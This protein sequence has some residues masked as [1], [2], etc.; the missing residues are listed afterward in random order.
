MGG[1]LRCWEEMGQQQAKALPKIMRKAGD[2]MNVFNLP[3]VHTEVLYPTAKRTVNFSICRCWQST[4]FPI[5]DNAHKVL[6]KQGCNCGP[7]MLEVRQAPS[8]TEP[9]DMNSS[10]ESKERMS[11][12]ALFG[13]AASVAAAVAAGGHAFGFF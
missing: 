8:L 11:A 1:A 13:G 12:G 5:C 4:K 9:R 2:P 3:S 7:T 6:Q 10:F